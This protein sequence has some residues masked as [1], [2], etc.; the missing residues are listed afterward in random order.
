MT[1]RFDPGYGAQPFRGLCEQYPE[2]TVYPVADFRV[3]WGPVFHR[4]RLDGSARV[5]VIGQDPAQ[6]E[7]MARRILVGTAGRRLQGLLAKLGIERSYALVNTFLYSVYGQ[8]GGEK[9]KKDAAIAAYRNKWLDALLV[10]KNVEA[11][12][13]L[14][15]LADQAWTAYRLTPAGAA[16]NV[17]YAHVTH[18]TQPESSSRSGQTTLAAATTA[19]LK[20]WNTT[21]QALKPAVTH[22]DVA[23]P[24]ALYGTKWAAGDE[25]EIPADDFPAGTPEWMRGDKA[26][27]VR[28]GATAKEKRYTIAVTVPKAFQV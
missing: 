22:P 19:L 6:H 20:N 1:I 4:G 2:E 13:A 7:V 23:K 10:G 9:H 15:S 27:A 3:E 8:G 17:A 26:W 14:G 24:L 12:I 11:V 16:L 18:P 5:L 21:L 25:V 28:K